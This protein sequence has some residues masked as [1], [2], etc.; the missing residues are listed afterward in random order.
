[1]RAVPIVPLCLFT[2]LAFASAS[3]GAETPTQAPAGPAGAVAPA[4]AILSFEGIWLFDA[5]RSDDPKKLLEQNR[6][7][8]RRGPGAGGMRPGG[9]GMRGGQGGMGPRGGGGAPPDMAADDQAGPE[10][11]GSRSSADPRRAMERVLNPAKK[12][13]VYVDRDRFQL[14]EDE[15]SPLVYTIADSSAAAGVKP[16]ETEAMVTIQG[17]RLEARQPLGRRGAMLETFELSG[18]GRTLTIRARRQGGPERA[19]NPTFTRVYTRYEGE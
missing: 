8:S 11:A 5:Q 15:G 3:P 18:D 13:V 10:A 17:R 9:G 16:P 2:A 14:E 7:G 6:P 1:M 19:T 12:L 4:A